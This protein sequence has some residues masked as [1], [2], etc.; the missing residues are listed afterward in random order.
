MRTLIENAQIYNEGLSFQGSLLIDGS[1]IFRIIKKSTPSYTQ[2]LESLR[3][4]STVIDATGLLLLPGIIDDQVHFRT[5]GAT[6]KGDIA[7]ESAAAALGGVTSFMDMPNN[8]PPA[9]TLTAL[10]GKYTLAATASSANYSFYLGATNGNIGEILNCDP[11]QIC[12]VK[13]FMGSS[14]GNMLVDSP[15]AL[16]DIFSRS[17][18]PVATHCED[19]AIINENLSL[20]QYRFPAGI[21][22]SYHP[23]IRSREACIASTSKAIALAAQYGTRL[24]VL[25]VSTAEEIAMLS[26]AK[27]LH[28]GIT[29]EI[30]AHYLWFCDEDYPRC[31]SLIKCNPAIKTRSDMLALRRA[32]KEGL[33]GAVATDHAPHLFQEKQ[34]PYLHC[35]SGLPSVEHSLR[36]MLQLSKEG[37][38]TI[39][40]VV[41]SMCHA[42][43]ECFQIEGRG[44]IREGYFADLVLVNPDT[45]KEKRIVSKDNIHYKCGW[46]PLEGT[47]LD[48]SIEH[49]FINGTQVVRNGSLTGEHSS[50]RLTFNRPR[51]K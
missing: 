23:Q 33:P 8:N 26:E 30:C 47:P 12:G 40:D 2:E 45:P 16:K 35:P 21:P 25:H 46:S 9:T 19:E 11:S 31:G 44:Y 38:F 6:H 10:E 22:Y 50:M 20:A 17:P 32:V 29:F 13:V 51:R 24:H 37:A 34:A 27:R 5:P 7:S 43:A 15:E 39:H 28:P 36:M 4:G 14:T 1:R 42:P 3:R 48:F 49:T 18:L 41:R